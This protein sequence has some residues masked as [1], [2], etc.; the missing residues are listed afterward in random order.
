MALRDDLLKHIAT[1]QIV[2]NYLKMTLSRFLCSSLLI[3]LSIERTY[4]RIKRLLLE[5]YLFRVYEFSTVKYQQIKY[6]MMLH[7][8]LCSQK[9]KT[10]F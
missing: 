5:M 8:S 6:F 3:D 7:F 10:E 9:F 4:T 1:D 2:V